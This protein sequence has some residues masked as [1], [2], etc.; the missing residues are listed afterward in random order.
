MTDLFSEV[1]SD[2]ILQFYANIYGYYS[3][4]SI[5]FDG[6]KAEP[7]MVNIFMSIQSLCQVNELTELTCRLLKNRFGF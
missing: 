5:F 7:T 6:K 2:S 4:W 1:F 3:T